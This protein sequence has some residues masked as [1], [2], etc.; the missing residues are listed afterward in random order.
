MLAAALLLISTVFFQ[1]YWA[2]PFRTLRRD[3]QL[4]CYDAAQKLQAI[5]H[6]NNL[7]VIGH[8][9][10]QEHG[11]GWEAGMYASYFAQCRMIAFSP[12]IPE[13][14]K[15]EATQLD[16][17]TIRPDAILL[18]GTRGNVAYETLLA[19]INTSQPN[20]QSEAIVDPPARELGKLF[21]RVDHNH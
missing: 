20:L 12:D 2:S 21:W 10:Y 3:Y 14:D 7:V 16:L 6:C 13:T 4:G 15:V 17:V 18:F 1:V 5:P 9:P 11:V 19:A 8:G